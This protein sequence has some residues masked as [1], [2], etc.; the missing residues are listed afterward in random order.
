MD[1]HKKNNQKEKRVKRNLKTLLLGSPGEITIPGSRFPNGTQNLVPAVDIQ[2]GVRITEDGR[3]IKVLEIVPT[4]FYLKSRIEQQNIIYYFSCYLKIA[5]QSLQILVCTQ[6]ADIDAYCDQMEKYYN[7]EKNENCKAM[8]LED[9]QL[10]NYLASY[11]AVTRRFYLIYEY[12]GEATEFTEISKELADQ[13]ETAYQ[14]LD[15]C[16]LEVLRHDNYDEFL[17]RTVY[18]AYH[19]QSARNINFSA[20]TEQVGP[21]FNTPEITEDQ[22]EE[23]DSE[24]ITTIQDVL[25]PTEA[26]LEHS[27]YILIDGVYHAYLY[28]TGYSYPTERG[29]AW[30]SRLIELGDGISL[31]FFLEKKRKEQILSK[32][33]KT[34]MINRSRLRDIEDTRADY[35]ELDDAI[36]SGMYIKDR[37]NRDGEDFFYMHTLIEVTALDETTLNKR[38]KQVQNLCVSMDMTARRADWCHEQC[39]RS[40]LPIAKLDMDIAKRTQRNVLTS[41]AAG[42]FPFSSFELCDNK[43]V[44]MGINLHNNSAVIVDNFNSDIYSNGNL[45]IFGMSGA[46]KT[47]T[48]PLL[49]MR[50]RMCGVQV[51]I[52]APEKGFEYR[53]ACEAIGGQFL[54]LSPGSEDCINLM[55]IRRSTLDIDS[56]L[57][58]NIQRNDSVLLSKVQ[59]LHTSIRLR[60]PQITPEEAY[61]LNIAIL[62]CYE[63]FGITKDNGSLLNP[64]GSFKAMPDFTHLYSCLLKYPSLKNVALAVK[65]I[66]DFGMGGQTNV[67]LFS[68]FIVLDTSGAKKKDISSSTFVATS[69]IRDELSRSRTRK[70]AVLGDELW[71]IAGEEGNEQAADFIIEM[72]KLIRGYGAIFVSATQNTLDYFALRDGKF[73]DALLNNSRLKL[74]LQMEEAEAIKLQ[75]KLGLSDEEVMQVVRCGRGQGLLCAGKNRIGIEIRSSQTEYELITTNRTDLE[76]REARTD[77]AEL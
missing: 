43:G 37:L 65:E 2:K 1:K 75:E 16:G 4:N 60:Y 69:F 35:E 6:R 70:K 25:A 67:D 77:T 33:V 13:A 47:Y 39:F 3:Y 52:I 26:D 68:S 57:A 73:G 22:L 48:L 18:T 72:V 76:K 11:E 66:I 55:E 62:E 45:A 74:L 44:L 34:T 71:V 9:A 27:K 29:L 59:D 17:L 32:V 53:C 46:G 56:N 19:K 64:D 51:F 41:G 7:R 58:N 38:I 28:I 10:V 23:E 31:S 36:Y 63:S 15:Y 12:K 8:I 50:L 40:M 21:V 54:R 61:Q 24:G 30:L 14:Y 49:A 42:A 5:P 20:L